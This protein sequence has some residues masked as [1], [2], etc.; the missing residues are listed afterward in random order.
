MQGSPE[1]AVTSKKQC[2]VITEALATYRINIFWGGGGE[3]IKMIN[4]VYFVG[5]K[6]T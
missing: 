3:K 1:A 5:R 4:L 2:S 6:K